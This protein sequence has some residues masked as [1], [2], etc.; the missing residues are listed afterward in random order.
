ML[1]IYNEHVQDLMVHPKRRPRGGLQI[2]EDKAKGV[3]VESLTTL[4][5][6]SYE[7]IENFINMGTSHRTI[8]AT[9]MNAT[10]SRAHT[11][12]KISFKQTIFENDKPQNQKKS[13]IN[14]VDLAGSER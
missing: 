13:D 6:S 8:G 10:S 2:R 12:T 14:L 11:V 5:V 1:E 7:D 9:N 4:P 3:Y